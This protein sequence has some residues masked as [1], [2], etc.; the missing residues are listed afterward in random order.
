[1]SFVKDFIGTYGMTIAYT[2]LTAIAG[3]FGIWAKK[4]YERYLNDKTKKEVAEIC[5]QAV[6]QLYKELHGTE[7]FEKCAEAMAQMLAVRGISVT[8]L[9]IRILCEAAVA[10]FNMAFSSKSVVKEET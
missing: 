10:K 8:D 4:L 1:M 5:V 6:E 7:K 2:A 9:E 3:A